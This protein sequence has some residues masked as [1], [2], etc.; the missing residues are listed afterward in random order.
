MEK[1]GDENFVFKGADDVFKNASVSFEGKDKQCVRAKVVG[2]E[3]STSS[4]NAS[5]EWEFDVTRVKTM[6]QNSNDI[7]S[8]VMK[9]PK[10]GNEWELQCRPK[11]R[12][13]YGNKYTVQSPLKVNGQVVKD[14]KLMA[15][16]KDLWNKLVLLFVF[17]FLNKRFFFLIC[18]TVILQ[19]SASGSNCTS[20][21]FRVFV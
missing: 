7:T 2:E 11:D 13:H 6:N 8:F 20:I 10:T 14:E 1:D 4:W 17:A 15:T 19:F 3:M 18:C 21:G 12:D 16:C 9:N 5:F